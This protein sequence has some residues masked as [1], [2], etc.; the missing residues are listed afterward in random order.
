M[1]K[2]EA[3]KDLANAKA[4]VELDAFQKLQALGMGHDI[5]ISR[6][7]GGHYLEIIPL[8]GLD[9]D[10][11]RERYGGGRFRLRARKDGTWLAGENQT[12]NIAGEPKEFPAPKPVG[13]TNATLEELRLELAT[14]KGQQGAGGPSASDSVMVAVVGALGPI[15][16]SMV[17]AAMDRAPPPSAL[18]IVEL[19]RTLRKDDRKDE[20]NANG[21]DS[22]G[23]DPILEH[24]GIPLVK[25]I[26]ELRKV[27]QT[28]QLAAPEK[29]TEGAERAP[30]KTPETTQE[31]AGFVARWCAPHCRRGSSPDL[32][33][34]VLL[35]DLELM[36]P[37]LRENVIKLSALPNVLEL[38]A[39]LSPSVAE[40]KEWHGAFIAEVERLAALELEPELESEPEPDQDE[41][42]A[43]TLED[44]QGGAPA[45][46][47]GGLGDDGDVA[48]DGAPIEA[49]ALA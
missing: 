39:R 27:E 18:E 15:L 45:D 26:R 4:E 30:P 36:N 46:S 37:A 33:A 1:G 47:A 43:P 28:K 44:A 20:R 40:D 13:T 2:T 25:E 31:L 16:A 41:P 23:L 32:R 11:I 14:L 9:L 34:E 6:M 7:P 38:W 5:E 8:E 29:A 19:A 22:S 49:G 17:K 35:E 12:V 3:E 10:L 24:L 21:A 48:S 42:A